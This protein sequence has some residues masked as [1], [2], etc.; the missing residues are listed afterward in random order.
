L[1]CQGEP[2]DEAYLIH[3]GV[4]KL[5][6]SDTSGHETI[7]GLRGPGWFLGAAAVIVAA[8]NP[9]SATTLVLSTLEHIPGEV[10]LQLL[11]RN[12]ELAR[13]IH[14]KHSQEI[15]E[16]ASMLGELACLSARAT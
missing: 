13:K 9:A 11:T 3:D 12:P 14:E 6:W 1:F 4:I 5:T 7:I 15:L 8:P 10:F 16:Q 2:A